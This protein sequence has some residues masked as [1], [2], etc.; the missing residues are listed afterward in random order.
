MNWKGI[1][2]HHSDSRDVSANEIDRWHKERGWNGIGYH[3]VIRQDGSIEPGRELDK[4]GAH[5]KVRNKTHIGVC[6]A[7]KIHQQPPTIDQ[8][9]SLQKLL[10]GLM[11]RFDIEVKSIDRHHGKCPGQ[12]FPMELM[13]NNLVG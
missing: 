7:G 1:V 6:L 13:K 3:F 10:R 5:D 9:A 2:V 8:L 4:Q 11:E 12:Y